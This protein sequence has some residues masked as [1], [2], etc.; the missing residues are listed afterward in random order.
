MP[1]QK[2]IEQVAELR[3]RISRATITVGADY[4]GLRVQ[5]MDQLRRRLREAGIEVRVV[6]NSL[7]KLAADQ[8]EMSDLMEI[9][10]GPTA[11]ALGYDEPTAAARAITEYAQTAPPTFALRGAYLDGQVVSADDLKQLVR[12]PA[13]PVMI[14]QIAGQLQ[15]PLA[16]LLAL[17]ESPLREL[18][19]LL[20]A[21]L[22]ELPGLIEARA[23]QL[24]ALGLPA[25]GPA[26]AEAEAEVAPEPAEAP[27]EVAPAEEPAAAAEATPEAPEPEASA[28]EPPVK[29]PP[30]EEPAEPAPEAEQP[31]E[32][33]PPEPEE[34]PAGEQQTEQDSEEQTEEKE[35]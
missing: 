6:K 23:G 4:R 9:V 15:S 29:E 33:T 31:T 22:S 5:E 21:T 19:S 10:E 8:A 26:S 2:K 34:G 35:G 11:L 18:A 16:G 3:D 12:L 27:G 32:E 1:T 28:E 14:A 24:E 7:L 30:A 13:K 25:G 20:Q 17:L